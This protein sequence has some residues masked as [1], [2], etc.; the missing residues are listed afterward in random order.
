MSLVERQGVLS[1]H[2]QL[3]LAM[4][5]STILSI[6]EKSPPSDNS[7]MKFLESRQGDCGKICCNKTREIN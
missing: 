7:L 2:K 1:F 4:Q 6:S 5:L 3:D